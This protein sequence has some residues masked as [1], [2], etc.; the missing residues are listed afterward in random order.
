MKRGGPRNGAAS[1]QATLIES[2]SYVLKGAALLLMCLGEPVPVQS[3]V[4]L[5]LQCG[6]PVAA[7]VVAR[8]TK[9]PPFGER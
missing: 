2:D 5:S 7:Q 4:L 8:N 9:R 6:A 3:R 1:V